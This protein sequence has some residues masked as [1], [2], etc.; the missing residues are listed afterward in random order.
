MTTASDAPPTKKDRL[1][2]TFLNHLVRFIKCS[3][4]EDE[5]I[6]QAYF[7][8][9]LIRTLRFTFGVVAVQFFLGSIYFYVGSQT[10]SQW[11]FV[12]MMVFV[13]LSMLFLGLS[14]TPFYRMIWRVLLLIYG[15]MAVLVALFYVNGTSAIVQVTML[16]LIT[17]CLLS[18][19]PFFMSAAVSLMILVGFEAALASAITNVS[20]ILLYNLFLLIFTVFLLYA[21]W[22]REKGIRSK[23][24]TIETVK[25]QRLKSDSII[26]HMLPPFVVQKLKAKH[27]SV[28]I[29]HFDSV[30][31][32]FCEIVNFN[33]LLEKMPATEVVQLLNEVYTSFDRLTDVHGVNKVEHI[34]N[35]YVVSAGCPEVTPF[36]S[37]RVAEMG[38]KMLSVVRHFKKIELRLGI[39]TGAVMAGVIGFKKLSY[40]LFGDTINTASRM[41]SHGN[42]Q[43]IHVSE[44]TY[45][46]LSG[47]YN[48]EARG[49]IQV[50]GKG[51]MRT[52]FLESR[53]V[54]Q[55]SMSL[56]EKEVMLKPTNIPRVNLMFKSPAGAGAELT[57]VART[58]RAGYTAARPTSGMRAADAT[59]P[60]QVQAQLMHLQ[61]GNFK[62]RIFF[63]TGSPDLTQVQAMDSSP[64]GRHE[65]KSR[66]RKSKLTLQFSGDPE[67][68]ADFVLRNNETRHRRMCLTMFFALVGFAIWGI[69]DNGTVTPRDILPFVLLARYLYCL[70]GII[71]IALAFRF[72]AWVEWFTLGV[73]AGCIL[74]T[75]A[76]ELW[77][78]FGRPIGFLTIVQLV[79]N[80]SMTFSVSGV[81]F[82]NAFIIQI[83][84]L[85]LFELQ[86][87]W[88]PTPSML[89]YTFFAIFGML[90][91]ASSSY[92]AELYERDN[93]VHELVLDDE[94]EKTDALLTGLLPVN[95]LM[96]L[97][98]GRQLI[99]DEF[100]QVSIM[101]T[102]IV[103]FTELASRVTPS[104]LVEF[105]N[106][107]YSIFDKCAEKYGVLKIATIGDAYL[108]L[109][110]CPDKCF[111]HADRVADMA[112]EMLDKVKQLIAPDGT[113]VRVRVGI[114]T[115]PVV[116]GV[117][118]IKMIHYQIWGD[119]VQIASKMESSGKAS[120]IHV[121]NSTQR[122]LEKTFQ[123]EQA[124]V[125]K[126]K[127]VDMQT[128]F[129]KGRL[130]PS[131]VPCNQPKN[132][133]PGTPRKFELSTSMIFQNA[134]SWVKKPSSPPPQAPNPVNRAPSARSR[135]L[136][137]PRRADILAPSTTRARKHSILVHAGST[138]NIA[139]L[140]NQPA[141]SP[142]SIIDN[143]LGL[144][145]AYD[146]TDSPNQVVNEE[147]YGD[148]MASDDEDMLSNDVLLSSDDDLRFDSDGNPIPLAPFSFKASLKL[149]SLNTSSPFTSSGGRLGPPSPSISE[150]T[151]MPPSP[152][153][154]TPTSPSHA[155]HGPLPTPLLP[156]PSLIRS[157]RS[158]QK[159]P[160]IL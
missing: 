154:F 34:G 144:N 14:Y 62:S 121:S 114:H 123:F 74:M 64:A 6:F 96:Q 107:L 24:D 28:I 151:L 84:G 104:K 55:G 128:Y 67:V 29:D 38:L 61:T 16:A 126:V 124:D 131:A 9:V 136:R 8:E 86:H 77:G 88:Q 66:Y 56:L 5:V 58:H 156:P 97:K 137:T 103:G 159:S 89:A 150:A 15:L 60:G 39:H 153:H 30:T 147:L 52:Y 27:D 47:K 157:L 90:M 85:G 135:V 31:V 44:A 69:Y 13:L 42:I 125:V 102:D 12:L 133:P 160:Q 116:A 46:L 115:G 75:L 148:D 105:L 155:R 79:F 50:K 43:R 112:L 4:H 92:M 20:Y 158:S 3:P 152:S 87:I 95:V 140:G 129:L 57:S 101:L 7:Y 35:V 33:A 93:Y 71:C 94:V 138:Q 63:L 51:T 10:M 111:D 68:E 109:S 23:F 22:M 25:I 37:G 106:V 149:P 110:G 11:K 40:H 72:R 45:N 54:A 141:E 53:K 100:E 65:G 134:T 78:H 1:E 19:M 73:L 21:A 113:Q 99:A 41:C 130:D 70:I 117:V 122:L 91:N 36:H 120:H 17:S 98:M 2:N 48:F 108:C 142:H 139:E 127:D 59:M 83:I 82:K 119:A 143:L 32:M 18:G 26:T 81:T 146:V 132:G 49:E 118:G 76:L 145:H 80:N